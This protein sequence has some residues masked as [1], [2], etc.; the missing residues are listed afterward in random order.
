MS[1]LAHARKVRALARSPVL[2]HARY[3]ATSATASAFAPAPAAQQ[4]QQ[5][6]SGASLK[7]GS[8]TAA[9]AA[10]AATPAGLPDALARLLG[11]ATVSAASS[12]PLALSLMEFSSEELITRLVRLAPDAGYFGYR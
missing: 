9:A 8:D 7:P 2:H 6:H 10:A 12:D 1:A 5:P 4:P 3:A 11:V